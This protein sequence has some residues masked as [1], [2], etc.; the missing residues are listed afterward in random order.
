MWKCRS[1]PI[2]KQVVWSLSQLINDQHHKIPYI[3][4]LKDFLLQSH[5]YTVF[6]GDE[7]DDPLPV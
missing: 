7:G 6:L 3:L 2:N 4:P 5:F 1:T